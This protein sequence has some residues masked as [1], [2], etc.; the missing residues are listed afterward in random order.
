VRVRGSAIAALVTASVALAMLTA[1]VTEHTCVSWVDFET[2]QEAYDDARLVV[3]GTA[4]P[5]GATRN[6][7]GVAMPVYAFDV[8]ETLK[9]EAPD[10]LTVTPTPL[11]C[12]GDA[13]EFPDG[14]DP[15]ATDEQLILF[16]HL[17]EGAWR[18]I[19][20]TDGVLPMPGD[21]MLPFEVEDR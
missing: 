16:L 21:G 8:A 6:V 17:D 4:E 13:S 9:G 3:A 7:L 10:D 2:P 20:P 19:T 1:C 11:T 14:V 18:L 5:T 12:M 15:L